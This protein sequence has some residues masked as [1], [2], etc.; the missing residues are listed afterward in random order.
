MRHTPARDIASVNRGRWPQAKAMARSTAID[1]GSVMAVTFLSVEWLGR[2]CAWG[3]VPGREWQ[4]DPRSGRVNHACGVEGVGPVGSPLFLADRSHS[5]PPAKSPL[6]VGGGVPR[7][8]TD[9]GRCA[10]CVALPG[11]VQLGESWTSIA[12]SSKA[13]IAIH[14]T[15]VLIVHTGLRSSDLLHLGCHGRFSA[16]PDRVAAT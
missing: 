9:W 10:R 14:A 6:P 3:Q 13:A 16:V 5:Q 1:E 7:S 4:P 2:V 15:N 8:A 11:R 12:T